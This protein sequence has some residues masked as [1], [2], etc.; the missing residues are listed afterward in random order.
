MSI[1]N[2]PIG[3]GLQI[4]SVSL[5]AIAGFATIGASVIDPTKRICDIKLL[6]KKD[7]NEPVTTEGKE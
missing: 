1:K 7:K 4:L 3:V 2:M 5:G 6:P